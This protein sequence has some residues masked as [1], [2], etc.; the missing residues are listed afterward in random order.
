MIAT[1]LNCLGTDRFSPFGFR[2]D[3]AFVYVR[4]GGG[5]GGEKKQQPKNRNMHRLLKRS[6]FIKALL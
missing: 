3:W 5:G 4:G 6:D 2:G 1:L